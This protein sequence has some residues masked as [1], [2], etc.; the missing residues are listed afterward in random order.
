MLQKLKPFWVKLEPEA[1]DR[2]P[3][4]Q[5][6]VIGKTVDY[7]PLLV[8]VAI[9]PRETLRVINSWINTAITKTFVKASFVH[10]DHLNPCAVQSA[11]FYG[12]DWQNSDPGDSLYDLFRNQ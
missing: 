3:V 12:C 10:H 9:A 5:F 1:L 2:V 6:G 11:N 8:I 4:D 7:K